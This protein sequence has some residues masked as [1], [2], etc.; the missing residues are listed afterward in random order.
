MSSKR[1]PIPDNQEQKLSSKKAKLQV[2]NPGN[3]KEAAVK[4]NNRAKRMAANA[5]ANVQRGASDITEEPKAQ[6]AIVGSGR[7]AA[8][9]VEY[10]EQTAL[11][12]PD[13]KLAVK[14]E[15]VAADELAALEQTKSDAVGPRR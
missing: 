9:G 12:L 11:A 14:Q 13:S 2:E 10:K 15:Q 5:A 1:Q 6:G 4:P 3:S 7:Q 8:Q